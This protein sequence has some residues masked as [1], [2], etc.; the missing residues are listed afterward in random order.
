MLSFEM[1]V[2]EDLVITNGGTSTYERSD[3]RQSER[4]TAAHNTVQ[5][6]G[7]EQTEIWSAFRAGR[8]ARIVEREAGP[9][10]LRAAHDGFRPLRAL[11]RRTFRFHNDRIAIADEIVGEGAKL[12]AVAR[13]HF[14]PGVVPTIDGNN[15]TA[16][17]LRIT[18]VGAAD[19]RITDFAYAADF[20]RR[21]PA[22]VLEAT[23]VGS[24]RTEIIVR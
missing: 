17:P 7:T 15:V 8:K 2:G 16:G 20:N 6:G 24:F 3:L 22:K 14:V 10:M 18:T 1:S 5:L 19:Q 13:I 23:F 9:D 11:H 4:S 21:L 12:P